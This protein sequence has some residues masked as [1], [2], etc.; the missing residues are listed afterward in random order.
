MTDFVETGYAARMRKATENEHLRE[1]EPGLP[2]QAPL[3]LSTCGLCGKR[4][5]ADW[6][7]Y[8]HSCGNRTEGWKP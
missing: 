6:L 3:A 4:G 1:P 2:V 7:D 5:P 8:Y